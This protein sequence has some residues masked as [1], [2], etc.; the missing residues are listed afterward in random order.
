M[1]L[2]NKEVLYEKVCGLESQALA[3]VGKIA[4]DETKID[5]W[6]IWS[7]ILAERTAFKHDIF[8]APEVKPEQKWIPCSE[9][10]PET[11]TAYYLVTVGNFGRFFTTT[12]PDEVDIV[13]W[14]Y[15]RRKGR[16][17]WHWCTDRT[18]VAWMP[19]PEPYGGEPG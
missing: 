19:L 2:I 1:I 12:L 16:N 6:R 14:D 4:N 18:V 17:S 13:R 5:E 15:D 7:A 11:Q 3:Y 10:S 9:R 8:D